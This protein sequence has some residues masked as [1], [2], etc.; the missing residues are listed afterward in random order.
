M[1]SVGR[2]VWMYA[3]PAGQNN[4]NLLRCVSLC[5]CVCLCACACTC[6]WLDRNHWF[7]RSLLGLFIFSTKEISS[8]NDFIIKPWC[9]S[10]HWLIDWCKFNQTLYLA[11][12]CHLVAEKGGVGGGTWHAACWCSTWT[13]ITNVRH[14]SALTLKGRQIILNL[15]ILKSLGNQT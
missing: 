6:H 12:C 2:N 14:S 1:Q 7:N 3:A 8:S 9:R 4:R 15:K 11:L 10:A 5:V 13:W